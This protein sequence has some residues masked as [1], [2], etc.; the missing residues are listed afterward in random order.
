M[1]GLSYKLRKDF[2]SHA[3]SIEAAPAQTDRP[4]TDRLSIPRWFD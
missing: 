1:A 2:Q 4:K 3:G